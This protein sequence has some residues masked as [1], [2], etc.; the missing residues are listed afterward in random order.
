MCAEVP[1][2]PRCE[3]MLVPKLF[4][5]LYRRL[6]RFPESFPHTLCVWRNLR[7]GVTQRGKAQQKHQVLDR[8]APL[9]GKI[10]VFFQGLIASPGDA[11]PAPVPR[12]ATSGRMA[13]W[14]TITKRQ[15]HVRHF[16]Y[17]AHGFFTLACGCAV[18]AFAALAGGGV[19]NEED[20]PHG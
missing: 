4:P 20:L 11:S 5:V 3:V 2:L 15:P 7:E 13:P 10:N 19:G 1:Q 9:P 6:T 14:R 8:F 16:P 18:A 12:T 17:Q